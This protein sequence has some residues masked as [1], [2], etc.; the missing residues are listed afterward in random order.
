MSNLPFDPASYLDMPVDQAFTAR[1][2]L[3]VGEYLSTIKE[4]RPRQ[5]AS[6]DGS[7]SGLVFDVVHTIDVPQ[8]VRDELGL[9]MP[10]LD[11]T[12][13]VMIDLT[14][15]GALDFSPGR[16]RGLRL[17]RES[18]SMNEPGVAFRASEMAGKL[19]RVKISHDSWNGRLLEKIDSVAKAA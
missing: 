2:P 14:E 7:K 4:I 3:P 8:S 13:G 12:H 19:V 10:T 18:L 17:Y 11:L 9:T 16:N 1:P 6:K 5:W 15:S